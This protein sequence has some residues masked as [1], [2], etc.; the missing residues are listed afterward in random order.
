MIDIL[1]VN[2]YTSQCIMLPLRGVIYGLLFLTQGVAIGLGYCRLAA[3]NMNNHTIF[4][5]CFVVPPRNQRSA[6]CGS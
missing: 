4:L 6:T 1:V 5:D 2:I 3:Y